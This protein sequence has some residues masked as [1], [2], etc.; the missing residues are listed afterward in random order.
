MQH[1]EDALSRFFSTD[2]HDG[3]SWSFVSGNTVFVNPKAFL[4]NAS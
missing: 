2:Y 3:L 1:F 4:R